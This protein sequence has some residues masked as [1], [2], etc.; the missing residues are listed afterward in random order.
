[1]KIL[2]AADGSRYTVKAATFIASQLTV[3]LGN[4]ELHLLHVTLP[5]PIGLAVDN[6]R[7]LLGDDAVDSYYAEEAMMALASA[8]NILRTHHI[9]FQATYKVG[10]IAEEIQSYVLTNSIEMIVMGSHGH[11]A[12]ANVILG[13]VSTKILATTSVPVLIMR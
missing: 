2:F 4:G 1:M 3:L 9:A 12:L 13:S 7:K 10:Q 11:G 8:E 5:L 6:A